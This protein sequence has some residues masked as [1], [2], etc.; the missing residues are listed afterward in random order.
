MRLRYFLSI[1]E[2][3]GILRELGVEQ[4]CRLIFRSFTSDAPAAS[5]KEVKWGVA[6]ELFRSGE[7]REMVLSLGVVPRH[8]RD[9]EFMELAA[10]EL[11]VI[12]GGRQKEAVLELAEMRLFSKR[13]KAKR[14][15]TQLRQGVLMA[16]PH[17][18]LKTLS[19]H[20]YADIIYSQN[21][22]QLDLRERLHYSKPGSR[23]VVP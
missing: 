2:H 20:L 18:G 22:R 13:S 6:E 23:F 16:C 14:L 21:I 19:G 8:D 9:W 15:F 12:E 4:Q 3:F 11:I 5:I 10:E 7:Y 1:D 17:N